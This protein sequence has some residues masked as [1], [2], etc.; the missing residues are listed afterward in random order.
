VYLQYGPSQPE[1]LDI[2][3]DSAEGFYWG[4]VI[5]VPNTGKGADFRKAYA[6]KYPG[7]TFGLVYTGWCYDMV[8]MLKDAWSNVDP[9][10]AKGVMAWIKSHPYDGTTGHI[11][12]SNVEAPVYPEP[13]P[14][15]T[16]VPG[17]GSYEPRISTRRSLVSEAG[18]GAPPR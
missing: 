7:T 18:I 3:G 6:A 1:F 8:H 10:D 16:T 14:R 2:A 12:F 4:T 11:D 13:Y 15:K 9:S 17:D 5:G